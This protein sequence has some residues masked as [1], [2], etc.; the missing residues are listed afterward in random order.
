MPQCY[1]VMISSFGRYPEGSILPEYVVL[2][3]AGAAEPDKARAVLRELVDR[4]TLAPTHEPPNI[5]LSAPRATPAVGNVSE[6]VRDELNRLRQETNELRADRDH[7]KGRCEMTERQHAVIKGAIDEHVIENAHLKGAC[8][9][10]QRAEE[11]ALA[12]VTELEAAN[13]ALRTELEMERATA[14]ARPN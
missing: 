4:G 5:T 11:K 1:K 14:P 9:E 8:E 2:A 13:A 7:W 3:S 10:H 12:R 6:E